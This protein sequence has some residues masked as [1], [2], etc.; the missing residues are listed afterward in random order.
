MANVIATITP[1]STSTNAL[2]SSARFG[3]FRAADEIELAL[4]F[5]DAV[6]VTRSG[7]RIKECPMGDRVLDA[8]AV[9][10]GRLQRVHALIM[11]TTH[12][13]SSDDPDASF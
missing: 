8:N 7:Q 3:T 1:A 10:A 2:L 9:D 4:W 11:A 6:Y 12:A 5:H 13:A